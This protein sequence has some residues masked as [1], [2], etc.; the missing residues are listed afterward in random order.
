MLYKLNLVCEQKLRQRMSDHHAEIVTINRR[1][2]LNASVICA[3]GSVVTSLAPSTVFAAVSSVKFY[4][5]EQVRT[6]LLQGIEIAL[7]DVR[8]EIPHADGHP[9]FAAS[10]P[11]GNIE[12]NAYSFL[13][14]KQMPIV[15]IDNGGG[16]A[17]RAANKFIELGYT[18]VGIFQGGIDAWTKAGGQLFKDINVPSK[19]FGEFVE[20]NK[21]TPSL[22]GAQV[23]ALQSSGQVVVL[24]VRRPDEYNT[25][26]IPGAI[27]E[28]GSEVVLNFKNVVPND[29]IT[30]VTNCAGRTRGLIWAQT[31]INA[32]V[33]NPVYALD[34]GTIKWYLQDVTP[35]LESG[36][37]TGAGCNACLLYTSPSPRD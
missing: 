33:P 16:L 11:V 15:M 17:E 31:L 23:S 13:P 9:L 2:L 32:G 26:R 5:F 1:D 3:V 24:D 28:P 7:L 21:H 27:S 36:K 30:V 12:L 34:G 8:E 6:R 37:P 14:R 19:S 22:K 18:D 20:I 35:P 4:T 25:F 29:S 10:F